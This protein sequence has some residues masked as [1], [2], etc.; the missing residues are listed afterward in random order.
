MIKFI[1]QEM[2]CHQPY[3]A[4]VSVFKDLFL[5]FNYFHNMQ[6]I[7]TLDIQKLTHKLVILMALFSGG[8]RAQVI[9]S[10]RISD[11]KILDYEVV[12]PIMFLNKQTKPTKHMTPLCF[13]IYNK[14]PNH[15][16]ANHLN[17]YLK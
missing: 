4:K 12:M 10:I 5:L 8:Q 2:Y 3:I 9:Y 14:E 6:D 16:V 13:Q 1:W 15:C 11:I 7:Q 17:E